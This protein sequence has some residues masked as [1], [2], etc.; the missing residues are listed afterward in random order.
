MRWV[1]K[2]EPS[3]V[4]DRFRQDEKGDDDVIIPSHH[5]DDRTVSC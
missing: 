5:G 4:V 1:G 2:V 3:V